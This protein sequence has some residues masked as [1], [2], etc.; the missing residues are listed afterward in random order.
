MYVSLH[1]SSFARVNAVL[2]ITVV[3][4]KSHWMLYFL[5]T[6]MYPRF[7]I[8]LDEELE[9]KPV[10]VRVGQVRFE[11]TQSKA[12]PVT[13]NLSF[14]PWMSLVKRANRGRYQASKRIKL[15]YG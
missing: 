4:E 14:R 8:T 1:Y 10:M 2:L 9:A 5:V 12:G 11:L 6:A 3:L 7:M 13:L 15:R